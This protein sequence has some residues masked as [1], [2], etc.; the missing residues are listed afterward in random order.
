MYHTIKVGLKGPIK[1][2]KRYSRVDVKIQLRRTILLIINNMVLIS[3]TFF[4][5]G[6]PFKVIVLHPTTS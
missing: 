5:L 4:Q 6:L 3:K 2:S 1:Y